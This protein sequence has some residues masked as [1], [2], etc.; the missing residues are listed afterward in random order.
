MVTKKKERKKKNHRKRFYIVL[1]SLI[2][3]FLILIGSGVVYALNITRQLPPLEQFSS[4]KVSQSAKIYDRTGE[5]LLYKMFGEEK[6]TIVPFDKIPE[7]MKKA[8][9]ATEDENFYHQPAFDWKGILRA[10]IINIKKGEFAQGG[11]TITQ[12]LVKNVFLTNEK[13]IER[14]IKELILA[15]EL[16]SKYNKKEIFSAY[17]NQIPYGSNAYGVEAASQTFFNKPVEDLNLSEAATLAALPKAPSYYSPWG[18]HV[19]ELMARRDYILNQMK[20]LGFITK[21]KAKEAKSKKPDFAPPSMG[22]IKAPHFA[23]TIKDYLIEKYGRNTVLNSGFKIITT[24]DWEIQQIA[25]EVVMSGAKRNEKLYGGK[26]A[27]LV[28]Q[29]P[30]TGQ[31]LAMVGSRNWYNDKIDGKFNVATQGKRQPGSALKPFI[32]LTAF[33]K[34][35][36]PETVIFDTETEFVSGDPDCPTLVTPKSE[37]NEECFNPDNFDHVFRGPVSMA[38]G[39]AQ[40]INVPSVKTLYLAGFNDVLK[41]LKDFGISTLKERWRYGLSLVLGGGEIK[42]NELVNAYATLAEQGKYHKQSMILE[43]KNS[44]GELIEKYN[45][46]SQQVFDKEQVKKINQILSDKQLRSG[47]FHSSL[48]MTLFDGREVALKT[49]TTDDYRDA[50]AMGY[51]PYLTV[52]V[53]AGNSDNTS[54]HQ[55]GSSI[56]AAVPMWSD[57]LNQV[58]QE[59]D[60]PKEVFNRPEAANPTNKPMLNGQ[61]VFSPEINNT[62]Y[63]QVHSI[64]HWVNKDNPLGPTLQNP[65]QDPQY[66]NWGAPVM[67]WAKNNI[68]DFYRY[69]NPLPENVDFEN[70]TRTS[71]LSIQFK[72]PDEGKYMNSPFLVQ[73]NINSLNGLSNIKLYFNNTLLQNL[74]VSGNSYNYFYYLNQPLSSQNSIELRVTDKEGIQKRKSLIVFKK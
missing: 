8:T 69:N 59:K 62:T 23:L 20:E 6:R 55:K 31:V 24:L 40:S 68:P 33:E 10:L 1:L 41:T 65:T 25:E 15:I 60:F 30:K 51:T 61:Y 67:E 22:T 46:E 13:T 29:D 71:N 26:N 18:N 42:L 34:G 50:W 39:L 2:T 5:V 16:E 9:L 28:A 63:P 32:Y 35:Y 45:N 53:W 14:K 66:S 58:F 21:K 54:M 17:L 49:G 3:L 52:G 38:E 7:N 70:N 57:F 4:R 11:S 44:E 64:L 43:I 37:K 72:E 73:A 12:Q 74:N 48:G 27:A 56:L 47:L 19:N 36:S